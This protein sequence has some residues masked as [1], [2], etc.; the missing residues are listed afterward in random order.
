MK[1]ARPRIKEVAKHNVIDAT[2]KENVI[3][4]LST[5]DGGSTGGDSSGDSGS[6]DGNN[7]NNNNNNNGDTGGR[8]KPPMG[9]GA[10]LNPPKN[11]DDSK[12]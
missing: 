11:E 7:N 9:P 8:P 4:T 2:E 3:S 10:I 1:K 12:N 6:T 5:R